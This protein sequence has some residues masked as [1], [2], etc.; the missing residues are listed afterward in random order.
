MSETTDAA[1][2]PAPETAAGVG[3]AAA[4]VSVTLSPSSALTARS[5]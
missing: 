4:G 1:E 3:A 5:A 2:T